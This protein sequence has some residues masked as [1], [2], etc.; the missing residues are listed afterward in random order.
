MATAT[1][2]FLELGNF[3]G[4]QTRI[5]RATEFV[6]KYS[7]LICGNGGSWC[8]LDG[9]FGKK[10][11]SI[12]VNRKGK[13]RYSWDAEDEEKEQIQQE[14]NE[15]MKSNNIGFSDTGV[16]LYLFK[17]YGLRTT[18]YS[19]VIS[20][21]IK[22]E[23]RDRPCVACGTTSHIEIDHKNGLYND[24]RVYNVATQLVT[25]F[26][27]LCKHCNDQKR[28]ITKW[29]IKHKKR[30]PATMIPQFAYSNI[31]YVEGGETYDPN[32][33]NA[34][35]GTYWYDPVEL[36]KKADKILAH[37]AVQEY[38]KKQLQEEEFDFPDG[39]ELP[40]KNKK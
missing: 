38:L 29:Q 21:K 36:R 32:D 28:Q 20:K 11:K 39:F 19:R 30:Y 14:I 4:N 24:P 9:D 1:Q 17:I 12:T 18:D 25:D 7:I 33:P 15:Y 16:D 34:M 35:I 2:L 37:R 6:D 3:D 13:I 5:V 22:D 27:P 8:R 10:Y 23:L 31:A 40:C 26:Q